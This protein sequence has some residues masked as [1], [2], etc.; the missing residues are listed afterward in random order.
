MA[1]EVRKSDGV[2]RV[3]ARAPKASRRV[4]SLTMAAGKLLAVGRARPSLVV[5]VLCALLGAA[6]ATD[7]D[8]LVLYTPLTLSLYSDVAAL[9]ALLEGGADPTLRHV[10]WGFRVAY[11][12]CKTRE[13]RNVFRK[14]MGR[15]PEAWDWKAAHVPDALSEEAEAERDERE[16]A[17]AKEKK[18]K[19]E[20]ARKERRRAEEEARQQALA[21]L[22][23]A[24]AS[25]DVDA[26]EATVA[27]ALRVGAEGDVVGAAQAQ[28]A[29]L[30]RKESD[31]EELKRRER[32]KR[33]AAAEARLGGLSETQRAFML[34]KS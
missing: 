21:A 26:L 18:K 23:T 5:V 4:R 22:Q 8:V 10:R 15:S 9:T 33:A 34:G 17:K 31:P 13:A 1:A 30:K 7:I 32:E 28:L 24:A 16:K 29:E 19:A 27:E 12:L 20:K 6:T 2:Q 25:A 11:D 14:E 3:H